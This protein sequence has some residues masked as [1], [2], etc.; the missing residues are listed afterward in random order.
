[1]RKEKEQFE[2][3]YEGNQKQYLIDN[4]ISDT[5]YEIRICSIS[6]NKEGAWSEIKKVKI[7]KEIQSNILKE[8]NRQ[9]EFIKKLLEWTG[10]QKI[11]INI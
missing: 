7:L 9:N 6:D 2:K 1:M 4:L 11:R 10:C 5:N 8:S 3:I